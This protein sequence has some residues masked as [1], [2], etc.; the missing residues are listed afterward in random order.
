M[1]EVKTK[2]LVLEEV[3]QA[4]MVTRT[5]SFHVKTAA[6]KAQGEE[7]SLNSWHQSA[8]ERI[9]DMCV[10]DDEVPNNQV[11]PT[12]VH[13]AEHSL[14]TH[15]KTNVDIQIENS[16]L[17]KIKEQHRYLLRVAQLPKLETMIFVVD[18]LKSEVWRELC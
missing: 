3:I 15:P 6:M 2:H 1:D 18:R 5:T 7:D 8:N 16:K 4:Q 9:S 17:N 12:D 11:V 14:Q 13:L 10:K